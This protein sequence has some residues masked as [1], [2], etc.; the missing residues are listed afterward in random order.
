[1]KLFIM[2]IIFEILLISNKWVFQIR[3]NYI[4]FNWQFAKNMRYNMYMALIL[5]YLTKI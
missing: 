3:M 4:T 2:K 1:M 5:I